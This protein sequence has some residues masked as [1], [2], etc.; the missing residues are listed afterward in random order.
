MADSSS[1]ASPLYEPET[2]TEDGQVFEYVVGSQSGPVETGPN[3]YSP[4]AAG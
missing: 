1:K 3:P 2:P 4:L